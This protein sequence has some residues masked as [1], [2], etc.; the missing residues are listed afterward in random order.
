[1]VSFETGNETSV[2]GGEKKNYSMGSAGK[3]KLHSRTGYE[4]V[5]GK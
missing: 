3:V 1:M 4:G 2:K 5:E